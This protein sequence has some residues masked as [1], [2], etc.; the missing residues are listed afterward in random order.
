[1]SAQHEESRPPRFLENS[2]LV[3]AGLIAHVP[4]IYQVPRWTHGLD[5]MFVH[6]RWIEQSPVPFLFRFVAV[7]PLVWI[8]L[9]VLIFIQLCRNY[10]WRLSR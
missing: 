10:G 4:L 9:I 2:F 7:H 6:P 5:P 1:M 3:V 8:A